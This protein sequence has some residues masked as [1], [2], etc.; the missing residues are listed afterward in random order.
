VPTTKKLTPETRKFGRNVA[1]LRAQLRLTQEE[2]AEKASISTRYVQDME[3]GFYAPTI[4]L[5]N[6]LRQALECEWD[7]LLKGC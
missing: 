1:R 5:A 2:L 6:A 3:R 4:F 7:D